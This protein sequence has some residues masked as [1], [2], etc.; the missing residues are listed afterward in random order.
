[1]NKKNFISYIIANLLSFLFLIFAFCAIVLL[2]IRD[3]RDYSGVENRALNK[4]D[5]KKITSFFSGDFQKQLENGLQDQLIFNES[6][7]KYGKLLELS[8]FDSTIEALY[9]YER[10]DYIPASQNLYYLKNTDYIMYGKYRQKETKKISMKRI[11]NLIDIKKHFPNINLFVYEVTRENDMDFAKNYNMFLH[12]YLDKYAKVDSFSIINNYDTYKKYFFKTD[13][14]WNYEGQ[15]AGYL[16]IADLLKI[17]NPIKIVQKDCFDVKYYG[18]KARQIGETKIYD[19]L[20]AYKYDIPEFYSTVA[21]EKYDFNLKRKKYYENDASIYKNV[22]HYSQ[23]FGEDIGEIIYTFPSNKGKNSILMFVD[24]Y[25]NPINEAIASNYYHTYVVDL[26]WYEELIGE[27]FVL[28]QYLLNHDDI[29][30]ILFVGC[31]NTFIDDL[32]NIKVVE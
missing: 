1:M 11:D 24:S 9:D 14:H 15:Y 19:E 27:K 18:S 3:Q 21:G 23:L 17:K 4:I 16:E 10:F 22:A 30:D 6:I 20:C 5:L 12:K 25:S 7:K 13:H 2:F 29:S 32:F 28:E 31:I 8:I 26:R